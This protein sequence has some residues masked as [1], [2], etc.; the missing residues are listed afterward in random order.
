MLVIVAGGLIVIIAM[1]GLMIDGGYAWGKQR[2]TQNGAD[3]VAKAGTVAIQSYL[4]GDATTDGDVGCAVEEAADANG[5]DLDRAIYTDSVGDALSP[6]IEVGACAL[7]GGGA[8]PTGAQGVK[9]V[10]TQE[11]DTFLAGVIGFDTLTATADATAVV[12]KVAG[13]CP[14]EAGCGILP[15]TIPQVLDVCDRVLEEEYTVGEG[16]WSI[17]DE[18]D[19]DETNLVSLPLCEADSTSSAVGWLDFGCGN[20]AR[21]ITE[22]CND[23]IPIP[24]WLHTGPGNAN[25]CEDELREYTGPTW[26]V[27]EP[28]DQVLWIPVHTN[29]CS[30]QPADDDA[31]CEPLDAEWSGMGNNLYFYVPIWLGFK[32]DQAHT[33]G[34]DRE[35][36]EPFGTPVLITPDPPGKIGCLKGWFVNLNTGQGPITS[37]V[38]NPGDP[39]STG[40]LLIE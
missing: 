31:T 35:C 11:H 10:G 28:E 19:A 3:S 34:G 37:E 13:I 12:G 39:V 27:A 23:Y 21:Q 5:I 36:R 6:E 18:A 26:A 8:I 16:A 14:A 33:Q 1:V 24:A 38:I 22:P 4:A 20:L 40:I 25:C 9:A 2:Q 29:T 15:V 17:I 32:I 7:G 30:K